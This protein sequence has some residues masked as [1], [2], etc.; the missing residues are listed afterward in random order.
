[1]ART[2]VRETARQAARPFAMTTRRKV[3]AT[4][5]GLRAIIDGST[6]KHV[7]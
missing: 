4:P 7:P 2:Y 5:L 6:G 3:L 1:M